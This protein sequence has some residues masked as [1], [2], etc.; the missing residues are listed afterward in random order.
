MTP[1]H[2]TIWKAAEAA[3]ERL[4]QMAQMTTVDPTP[5]DAYGRCKATFADLRAILAS[6]SALLDEITTLKADLA[7]AHDEIERLKSDN[8]DLMEAANAKAN[9][10][11]AAGE[12]VEA[13]TR[14]ARALI[15]ATDQDRDGRWVITGDGEMLCCDLLNVL[16]EP[17]LSPSSQ[18]GET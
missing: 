12:R 11:V 5:L 17:A 10:A 16:N 14:H 9:A 15:N 1:D 18:G 2:A 13:L 6:E 4:G 8:T 3:R 7:T